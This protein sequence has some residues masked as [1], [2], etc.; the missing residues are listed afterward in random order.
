MFLFHSAEGL[1][2]DKVGESKEWV[3]SKREGCGENC[4]SLHSVIRAAEIDLG[5]R[6]GRP[7]ERGNPSRAG[8]HQPHWRGRLLKFTVL[9]GNRFCLLHGDTRR[10][11]G[12]KRTC[13]MRQ[14]ESG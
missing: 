8:V 9:T 4:L 10:P 14:G 6:Q 1:V 13:P 12:L 3:L 11:G 5:G 7:S 2:R